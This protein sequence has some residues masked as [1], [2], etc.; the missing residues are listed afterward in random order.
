MGS[1]SDVFD[2]FTTF[3]ADLIGV[4]GGSIEGLS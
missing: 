3:L 1:I 4:A 2:L